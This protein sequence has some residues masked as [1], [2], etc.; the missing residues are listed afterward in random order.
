VPSGERPTI[1]AVDA[2]LWVTIAPT[3][4]DTKEEKHGNSD[5]DCDFLYCDYRCGYG[6]LPDDL[7]SEDEQVDGDPRKD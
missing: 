1:P 3:S 6:L 7:H 2:P 4:T 5:R